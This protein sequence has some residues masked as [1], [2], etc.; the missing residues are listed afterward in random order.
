ME[1]ETAKQEE[2][3]MEKE[4]GT[5]KQRIV[6]EAM[7]LFAVNG[8]EAV[9]IREIAD[10]VG[11][12]NTALYKHFA[13][14]QEIFDT[15]VEQSKERYLAKCTAAVTEE[16]RGAEQVKAVCLKMFRYQTSDEWIVLFRRMLIL[17]Q[18]RNPQMAAIYK[19]FFVDIPMRRQQEIFRA[20]MDEGLMKKRDPEAL[21]LELYAPFFMYHTVK[22]D[23]EELTRL[24]ETHAEYFFE[25]YVLEEQKT[26]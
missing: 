18:F 9:S 16:I 21:A 6:E 19:E 26:C 22:R 7:K 3:A 13:S 17:E 5:T 24:F 14:K 25:N 4:K 12:G 10:A 11:I 20:L 23:S 1:T 2:D 15:I 8:Y